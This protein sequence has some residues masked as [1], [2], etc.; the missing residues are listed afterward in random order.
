[1]KAQ[2]RRI[3]VNGIDVPDYG[4]RSV[5]ENAERAAKDVIE[6]AIRHNDRRLPNPEWDVRANVYDKRVGRVE[7][8]M[9]AGGGPTEWLCFVLTPT[10]EFDHAYLRYVSSGDP[11]IVHFGQYDGESLYEQVKGYRP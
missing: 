2:A 11:A 3:T 4:G 7:M 9:I 5:Y 8:Y 1:M 10:G 6:R